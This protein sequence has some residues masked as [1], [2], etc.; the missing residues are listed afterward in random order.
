MKPRDI[1]QLIKIHEF[2]VAIENTIDRYGNES[3]IF[4]EDPDYQNSVSFNIMQIGEIAN[5]I[6]EEFKSATEHEQSWKAIKGMRNLFAH[7]A[8]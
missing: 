7:T 3:S 5:A 8:Q 6:S 2:C 4:M 1:E